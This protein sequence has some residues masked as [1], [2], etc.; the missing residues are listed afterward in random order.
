MRCSARNKAG[1]P[2]GAKAL[3]GK[4]TC[5]LHSEPAR[6]AVLG[7]QGGRRRAVIRGHDLKQFKPPRTA[8]DLARLLGQTVIDVRDGALDHRIGNAVA[9][10]AQALLRS[11]D[12]GET[13]GR[14]SAIEAELKRRGR[15]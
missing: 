13:D 3:R 11:I 4:A 12:A 1:S 2:C 15:A 8:E 9:I 6:A 10:L 5:F 14:L 7:A